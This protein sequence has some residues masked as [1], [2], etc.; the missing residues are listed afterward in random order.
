MRTRIFVFALVGAIALGHSA[1]GAIP[2][3]LVG[4]WPLDGNADDA[5]GNANGKVIGNHD[6]VAG[7]TGKGIKVDGVGGIVQVDDFLLKTDTITISAWI[8]GWKQSEWAGIVVSRGTS[9]VWMGF[10]N[11]DT[12][13]YVW[14]NN[15]ANTWGWAGG[16]KIP[17]DTWAF[18]AITVEPDKATSYIY[19]EAGGM[20]KGENKIPHIVE[21][22][23]KLKF[24][25]DECCGGDRHFKGIIDEV[26]IYN[27]ALSQNELVDLAK[28]GLAVEP[29]G[30]TASAWGVLKAKGLSF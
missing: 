3:D 18:A 13:T 16:A 22:L 26:M 2:P 6:W 21:T 27:R 5:A 20:T 25:W 1:F 9:A 4:Y 17:Q 7:H 8:N 11:G 15:A 29:T 14:N 28:V 30:K 24:G 12:L 23:D 10:G 19:T